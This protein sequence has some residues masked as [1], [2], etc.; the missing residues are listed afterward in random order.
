MMIVFKK[1]R[2][3]LHKNN[4]GFDSVV[5]LNPTIIREGY[6]IHLLYRAVTNDNFSSIRYCKFNGPLGAFTSDMVL[7]KL[8]DRALRW[9]YPSLSMD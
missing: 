8:M 6:I 4:L 2:I 5:V 9:G 7:L 3:L 1:E